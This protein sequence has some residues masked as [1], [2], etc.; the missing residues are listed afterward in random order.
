MC[1]TWAAGRGPGGLG[2]SKRCPPLLPLM[3]LLPAFMCARGRDALQREVLFKGAVHNIAATSLF[4]DTLAKNAH[5]RAPVDLPCTCSQ[6]AGT[7]ER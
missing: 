3:W 2:R 1:V 5:G 7:A 4:S 6:G